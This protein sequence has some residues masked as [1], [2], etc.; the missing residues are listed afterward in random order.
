M[1]AVEGVVACLGV[2]DCCLVLCMAYSALRHFYGQQFYLLRMLRLCT[3]LCVSVVYTLSTCKKQWGLP[4]GDGH[5]AELPSLECPSPGF[6]THCLPLL[7]AI[8]F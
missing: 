6:I 7:C 3:H 5:G 1:P 4:E 8:I 2:F